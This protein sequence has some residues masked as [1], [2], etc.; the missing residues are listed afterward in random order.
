METMT[1][2]NK[3]VMA[4]KLTAEEMM[5][6]ATTAGAYNPTTWRNDVTRMQKYADVEYYK[7]DADDCYAYDRFFVTYTIEEGIKLF[8]SFQNRSITSGGFL[9]AWISEIGIDASG[10][11]FEYGKNIVNIK[12]SKIPYKKEDGT[13]GMGVVDTSK[14]GRRFMAEMSK[15]LGNIYTKESI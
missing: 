7:V 3:G 14:D 9:Q 15:K 4:T 6:L 13:F 10:N 2:I 12:T 5:N 1:Q 8:S 11:L